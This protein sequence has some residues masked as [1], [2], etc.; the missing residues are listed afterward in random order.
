MF[1][2]GLVMKTFKNAMRSSTAILS[3]TALI[4]VAA[5]AVA[6][7]Q[8]AARP[9]AGAGVV[10]TDVIVT[11][12]KRSENIQTVPIAITAYSSKDLEERNI[13]NLNDLGS[14]TPG[15]AI[16]S[17]SGGTFLAIF[18]RG[19]APANTANDLNTEPQTGTFIDGIYQ[20]SRNTLDIISILDVGQIDIAKGPQ[21]A[22]YGRSTFAGAVGISTQDPSR[23]F[24]GSVSGTVGT[25]KDYRF[26]GSVTGPIVE[27]KLYGRIAAGYL[28]Y[29]GYGKNSGAPDDNLGGYN[30]MGVSGSL[31]FTPNER[32]TARLKG[33][34]TRSETEASPSYNLP[35]SANNCGVSLANISTTDTTTQTAVRQTGAPTLFCGALAAREVSAISNIS[36]TIARAAQISLDLE[37][38]FDHFSIISVSGVTRATNRT[39]N[40]TDGSLGNRMGVCSGAACVGVPVTV[41]GAVMSLIPYTRTIVE[42]VVSTS[43]ERVETY[44]QELRIQSNDDARFQWMFGGFYFDSKIPL[45]GLGAAVDTNG[46]AATDNTIQILAGVPAGFGPLNGLQANRRLADPGA[47]D[48]G[49]Y[50]SY[51]DSSTRAESLFGSLGYKLTDTLRVAVEARYNVDR[52]RAQV[53]GTV[54]GVPAPINDSTNLG[55]LFPVVNATLPV[56]RATFRSF[57]PR[58]TVDWQATPDVFLYASA[59]KGVHSGGFNTG[60]VPSATGILPDEVAYDEESNWTYEVGFKSRLFERRLLLNASAFYT[61]WTNAQVTSYTAN[62]N[63]PPTTALAAII[64]NAGD[65]KVKGFETQADWTFN[66]YVTVGGSFSYSDPELQAGTYD[67]S[68][69]STGAGAVPAGGGG[70][71][72]TVSNS[73]CTIVPVVQAN[74]ATRLIPTVEGK[75]PVRSVK[76]SWNLHATAGMP[77]RGDWKLAARVDVNYQGD[78]YTN[79]IN[80]TKV[81]GRTLT[82]V[83]VGVDND[84]LS[85]VLFATNLFDKTFVSNSINQPFRDGQPGTYNIPEVYLG[86]GRRVGLTVSSKF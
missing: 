36:D 71:C 78:F 6:S 73:A 68:Q 13:T 62:A 33:F 19:I 69:S 79:L 86:E 4:A 82:N 67:T 65:L 76:T 81:A 32:F 2:G 1:S 18:L 60:S 54:G 74:G 53:F 55:A 57:T 25:D 61:D 11:A 52:K 30:K 14:N 9:A 10:L 39:F 26:R 31:E 48:A 35:I 22:I 20:T 21:S 70:R 43:T 50:T 56:Y 66:D 59:A 64:R 46:L 7:A 16:T 15:L 40:D 8:E 27:D 47:E 85:V 63:V 38:K 72:G 37:Y 45:A 5:P 28:T 23:T 17:I 12:R 44:S 51:S 34:A 3:A 77:L 58:F 29:D 24:G 49:L 42:N 75:R 80:T 83:R 84:Q 41:N